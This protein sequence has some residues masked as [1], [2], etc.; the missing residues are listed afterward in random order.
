[1]YQT[2]PTLSCLYSR[3]FL[4]QPKCE[5]VTDVGF[6]I[7]SSTSLY[8]DYDKAKQFVSRIA[9]ELKIS[10]KGNHAGAV[11]FSSAPSLR[12]KLS[13]HANPENFNKAIRKLP[14]LGGT[15]RIDLALEK[16]FTELFSLQNGMRASA[17]KLLIILTDGK[18]TKDYGYVPLHN[19]IAPFHQSGIKVIA[20]GV[21]SKVDKDELSRMVVDQN[22]LFLATDFD[23]LVSDAFFTNFKLDSCMAPGMQFYRNASWYI[24]AIPIASV[25]KRHYFLVA[26]RKYMESM[27]KTRSS[28]FVKMNKVNL[29]KMHCFRKL[30]AECQNSILI[31]MNFFKNVNKKK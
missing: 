4:G 3:F 31:K 22:N 25:I 7:D 19:A 5:V 17:S 1:M 26:L 6:L 20:I 16:A 10:S 23:E 9:T 18:Q 28:A 15:T 11:L 12:I 2:H 24:L 30:V 8:R 14:L 29:Q 13:D 27:L 21:G